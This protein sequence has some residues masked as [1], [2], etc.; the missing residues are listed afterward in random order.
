MTKLF[1]FTALIGLALQCEKQTT[2][3]PYSTSCGVDDPAK[4]LPWLKDLI[5]KADED[6]ATMAYKGNYLGKIYLESFR[7]QP[8]FIVDMMMGNGGI[9]LY[10]FHCDGQRVNDIRDDEIATTIA[11]FQRNN[12]VYS[13]FP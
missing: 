3:E 7:D 1:I 11:H 8:V 13:N 9:A 10:L 5:A 12:L 2:P 4:E 6:K